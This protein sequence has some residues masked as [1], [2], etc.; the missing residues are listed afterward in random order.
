MRFS[1]LPR[2]DVFFVLLQESSA[3]LKV[4][5]IQLLD[6]MENYENVSEKVAEIKRIESIGDNIIHRTMTELHK[7]F[8]TPIDRE[9]IAILGERLDDVVDAIEEAARYMVEYNIDAPTESA[10][11][12]SRIIVRCADI[13][14]KSMTLLKTR[15]SKLRQ[16]IPLKDELNSLEN[17]ADQVTSRAMGELFE[18]YSAVEIIKWKEVYDQLEGATDRCEEIAV[19][20]EGIVIKHA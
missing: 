13:V 12:L 17:E 15:G 3:N 10:Q 19:I 5:A 9:D 6:L 4:A 1:L 18:S 7:A 2:Q 8:I 14:E 11:E 20:L 16:L